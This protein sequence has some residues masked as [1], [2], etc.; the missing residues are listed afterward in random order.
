M[1][2]SQNISKLKQFWSL[3]VTMLKRLH[4]HANNKYPGKFRPLLEVIMMLLW[5]IGRSVYWNHLIFLNTQMTR[6]SESVSKAESPKNVSA[7]SNQNNVSVNESKPE[8]KP[9]VSKEKRPQRV[10]QVKVLEKVKP[11]LASKLS[12]SETIAKLVESRLNEISKEVNFLKSL[13]E[14]K[15][16]QKS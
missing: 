9:I 6:Q 13:S 8:P 12:Q 2:T 3:G 5:H 14:V 7:C 11:V 15:S 10:K 16:S 1:I 4:M